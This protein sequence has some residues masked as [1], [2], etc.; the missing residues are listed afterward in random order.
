MRSLLPYVVG[1]LILVAIAILAWPALRRRGTTSKGEDAPGEDALGEGT[2]GEGTLGEGT[3]G[4]DA[5]GED[6]LGEDALG[7]KKRR[8]RT[9]RTM[10]Q[11][12]TDTKS[13]GGLVATEGALE[14]V[15]L[16]ENPT[17]TGKRLKRSPRTKGRK[18][19]KRSTKRD[20][21]DVRLEVDALL[22]EARARLSG[23]PLALEA[24]PEYTGIE[25]AP[26]TP[27]VQPDGYADDFRE[28][29]E[30]LHREDR[31]V[32]TDESTPAGPSEL[33]AAP[34]E[35]L[36]E[37]VDQPAE[38]LLGDEAGG[39]EP[40]DVWGSSTLEVPALDDDT[41]PEVRQSRWRRGLRKES[42]P[43]ATEISQDQIE[44][45]RQRRAGASEA[46]TE[47]ED[48]EP[49]PVSF[50]LIGEVPDTS[51]TKNQRQQEKRQA[52]EE[53]KLS[54]AQAR[55]ETKLARSQEREEKSER[56][57]AKRQ[58]QKDATAERKAQ[59]SRGKGLKSEAPNTP[60]LPLDVSS[61]STTPPAAKSEGGKWRRGRRD[62]EDNLGEPS[63]VDAGP[64]L[65][66]EL[67]ESHDDGT[68]APV[69]VHD[70]TLGVLDEA[71]VLAPE[72]PYTG[73]SRRG[74]PARKREAEALAEAKRKEREAK[75]ERRAEEREHQELVKRAERQ[76]AIEEKRAREQQRREAPAK[77]ARS[78]KVSR[79][80]RDREVVRVA[81][82][83]AVGDL[84]EYLMPDFML[85]GIEEVQAAPSVVVPGPLGTLDKTQEKNTL[86]RARKLGL[87]DDPFSESDAT[88][89]VEPI[90]D[91]TAAGLPEALPARRQ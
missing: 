87:L 57:R 68:A 24:G 71:T 89:D 3:L 61:E 15:P 65:E 34:S 79:R 84:G 55:E 77:P 58:A 86:R 43:V 41:V 9:A 50:D 32:L 1:G 14:Q 38:V 54:K 36:Y 39:R 44:L 62:L 7:K 76:R 49:G 23:G 82:S 66:T 56:L 8:G 37:A 25:D 88:D 28:T 33:E 5:L 12:P 30:D 45:W 73:K 42:E 46:E 26:L 83:E 52:R 31:E 48:L 27:V 72:A 29:N 21:R 67:Y 6:A 47:A 81:R 22:A 91:W 13:S 17:N 75:R 74:N 2:L 18:V 40:W 16:V 63:W 4:E 90:F 60:V 35:P 10:G 51:L 64:S 70:E 19:Q 59:R 80:H 11:G 85:S 69:L 53:V 78:D 20:P